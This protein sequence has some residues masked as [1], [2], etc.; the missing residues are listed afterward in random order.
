MT[1]RSDANRVRTRCQTCLEIV[2]PKRIQD[3]T[4]REVWALT[5]ADGSE[6]VCPPKKGAVD[7]R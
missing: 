6:H 2:Y 3:G 1:R 5:N 7:Y 4:D